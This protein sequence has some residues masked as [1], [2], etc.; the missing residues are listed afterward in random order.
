MSPRMMYV[1][2]T[3]MLLDLFIRFQSLVTSIWNGGG[4]LKGL[5][6]LQKNLPKSS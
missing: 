2:P 4:M 6:L 5:R 3:T 1:L